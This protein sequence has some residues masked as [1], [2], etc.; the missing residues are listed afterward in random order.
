MYSMHSSAAGDRNQ[1]TVLQL[2]VAGTGFTPLVVESDCLRGTVLCQARPGRF[3][4]L[5]VKSFAN[6]Q[7]QPSN[8][9]STHDEGYLLES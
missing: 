4:W 5:K 7:H 8:D 1:A 6:H 9:E 3:C 2:V